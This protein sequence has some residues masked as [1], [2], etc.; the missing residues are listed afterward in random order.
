VHVQLE[1]DGT[2]LRVTVTDNGVGFDPATVKRGN[3]LDHSARRMEEIGGVCVVESRPGGVT[4]IRLDV[5]LP[6]KEATA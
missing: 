3:G 2:R 6:E 4:A 1:L 5:P